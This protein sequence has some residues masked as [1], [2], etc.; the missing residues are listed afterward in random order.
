[1]GRVCPTDGH[2]CDERAIRA[3]TMRSATVTPA[4]GRTEGHGLQDPDPADDGEEGGDGASSGGRGFRRY[5]H[6]KDHRRDLPQIVIGLAVTREGIPV[7]CW[8]WPGNTNDPRPAPC[9]GSGVGIFTLYQTRGGI[10][11]H[12]LQTGWTRSMQRV[13]GADAVAVGADVLTGIR[14]ALTGVPW[15]PPIP[16][17]T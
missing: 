16:A 8:C 9:D 7:R 1:M 3:C 14:D 10:G 12:L 17:P 6:S 5:G 15:R 13:P 4:T 2:S 11:A